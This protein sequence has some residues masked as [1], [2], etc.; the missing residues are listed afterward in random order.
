M[1]DISSVS[2]GLESKFEQLKQTVQSSDSLKAFTIAGGAMLFLA[3]APET[4]AGTTGAEFKPAW[5]KFVE[6]IGGFGGKMVAGVSLAVALVGSALRFNP[7]LV[8][9]SLGVGITAAFGTT[10]L[11]KVVGAII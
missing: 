10:V 6:L 7:Y 9:G 11:D 5:D 3:L 2:Q 8:F 4:M 1:A